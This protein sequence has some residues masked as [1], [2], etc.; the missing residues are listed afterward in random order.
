[1]REAISNFLDYLAVERGLSQNTIEAYRNDL[2]QLA[3]FMQEEATK[4]GAI[5]PWAG[6]SRQSMLSYLLNLKE[7]NYAPTTVARKVA[8]TKSFFS[9]MVSEGIIINVHYV[10]IPTLAHQ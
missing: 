9:F 7:R 5:P 10:T 8:A 2:Q 3:S 4:Q 1:M 6:F